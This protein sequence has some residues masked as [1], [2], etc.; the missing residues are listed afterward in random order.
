MR[1]NVAVPE[2][3]VDKPVLDAALEATTRL[4][5]SM[6]SRGEVPTF[7]DG[8]PHVRWKPEPPGAEHF[9]NASLVLKRGWGDCDDLAPWQAASLRHT[10]E[11]PGA[12]AEVHRSGPTTW[13]AVVR[14]SDGSIDDPSRAAGMDAHRGVIG[15]ALPLMWAPASAVSGVYIVRPQIAM[16]PIRGQWQARADLPWHWREHL[17]DPPTATDYAMVSLHQDPVASTALT[18]ACLGACE[19]GVAAGIADPE[20]VDRLLAIADAC[21]GCNWEHLAGLYG[22]EHADA[23][24]SV[25]GSFFGDAFHAMRRA[26]QAAT[27][28]PFAGKALQFIPGVGPIASSAYD[29][30]AHF[31]Q[32]HRGAPAPVFPTAAQHGHPWAEGFNLH[33]VPFN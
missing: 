10:G 21:Q 30:A 8:L 1:I 32:P 24:V 13:H 22:P 2:P 3:H 31:T 20:H 27:H 25:V 23:A 28:I 33:C 17:D 14:R 29:M 11:D 19:A 18:G 9:D 15:A 7:M 5:E 4:N 26:A 12:I 16:R 6:L